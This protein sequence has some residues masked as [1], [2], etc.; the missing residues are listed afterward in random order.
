MIHTGFESKVKIQ[1][2]LRNQLP[3]FI[4]NESPK[5]VDFLKQYYISQEYQGG[6]VDITDNLDQYLKVDNLTPDVVV[7]FTTLTTGIGT[8]DKTISV[9]NTKGFPNQYGLLKIND[10]I[11]TY[12]G[13]TSTTFTG[14]VRGFSGITS[15]HKELN[16]E[17]LVFSTSGI[18]T[19]SEDANIQNLSSLFLK[20]FYKKQKFTL[21][22][23]L[24][25]TTF[26]PDLNAG[27]F[28]KEAR[29]LYEAKGTDESFRI[30]F[31]A[32]YGETPKI[33][34]LEEF[35]IK[36]SSA[37]YIRRQ[38]I[39]A[40][41][42]SGNPLDLVGQTL[43]KVDDLDTNASISEVEAFS[44]V[45]VALTINQQYFKISL[46]RG[47]SDVEDA[48]QGDFKITPATRSLQTVS[49]GSSV[50]SVDSTVGF[51]NTGVLVSGVNTNIN[52]TNKSVNEFFGCSG[53]DDS[54]I[55]ATDTVRS[56]EIYFSY[57]NGDTTKKV[58]LRLTG[59]L[60]GFEKISKTLDV[61]EGQII[62][63]QNV[64]DS[65]TGNYYD[66][67]AYPYEDMSYKQ[68][69]ANSLIYNTSVRY[70]IKEFA[71]STT[72]SLEGTI[73]RSSL[74]IDDLVEIVIQSSNDVV[75]GSATDVFVRNVDDNKTVVISS[76][77]TP[78]TSPNVKYDIR[79]ISI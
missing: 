53:I 41:A 76:G 31:N 4:L 40:E 21:T 18:T 78:S 38:V 15:Y 36:P 61:D 10:E 22:P 19:H 54:D 7:G 50:I 57:E 66:P 11:I 44:R 1:Q 37:N 3:Q 79:S 35:L 64:G 12:T 23:G 14:C 70:N 16:E 47:Y 46:F 28:I 20:E 56:N 71:N 63:V 29:S 69:F 68:I 39:I 65:I 30:L 51:A 17:E 27:S 58:E 48:I 32:I 52:Y 72:I 34:N 73:D 59:V 9:S 55:G 49:I 75:H 74:K 45:G 6:P 67:L 13:K 5:T 60:S 2:I 43:F 8:A 25:D 24:E 77:F 33:V 26:A 42:I 62:G